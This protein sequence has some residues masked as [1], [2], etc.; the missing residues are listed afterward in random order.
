MPTNLQRLF[1]NDMKIVLASNNKHKIGELHAI[2]A[3]ELGGDLEIF[4]LSDIGFEGDIVEDGQTFEEN[5][6][7]KARAVSALGYIGVGDD[8]GLAVDALDG[9]PGVYS[10]RY[11]GEGLDDKDRYM[12]LLQNLRGQTTRAAHFACAIACAFDMCFI[13]TRDRKEKNQG[14]SRGRH[15]KCNGFARRYPG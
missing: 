4:S 8:S 14:D 13:Y 3:C 15:P 6:M 11:G 9:A 1:L 2:L 7:I 5:A 12:L 10:A